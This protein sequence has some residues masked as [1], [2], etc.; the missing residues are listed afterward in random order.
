MSIDQLRDHLIRL[1]KG[2]HGD[3]P[4]MFG[5][6]GQAPVSIEGGIVATKALLLAPM[7]L[8]QVGGF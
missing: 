3:L 5:P 4:V 1:S 8:D 7:T 2:G 6:E